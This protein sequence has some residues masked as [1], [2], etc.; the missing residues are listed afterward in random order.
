MSIIDLSAFKSVPLANIV[1]CKISHHHLILHVVV[2][3]L[4]PDISTNEFQLFFEILERYILNL[5]NI[6]IIGDFNVPNY[7]SIVNFKSDSKSATINSFVSYTNLTQINKIFNQN[8]HIL[9]LIF[10]DKKKTVQYV[11]HG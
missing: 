4:P 10:V 9:D 5:E 8:N 3:Y 11:C 2:I 7:Q 6:I 1:G